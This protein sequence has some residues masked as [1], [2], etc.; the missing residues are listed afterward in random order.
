M[1]F[2][3]TVLCMVNLLI[4]FYLRLYDFYIAE[5]PKWDQLIV[6]TIFGH[7]NFA[8]FVLTFHLCVH[9]VSTVL[10]I[11]LNV[12][13]ILFAG[14]DRVNRLIVANSRRYVTSHYYRFAVTHTRL[15]LE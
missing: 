5:A 3:Q 15:L 7:L 10:M 11:G 6:V 14:F 9:G 12:T 4:I 2:L 8:L 1:S 13:K